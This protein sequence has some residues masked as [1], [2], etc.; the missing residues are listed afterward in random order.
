MNRRIAVTIV[1]ALLGA[2]ILVSLGVWQ[3]QRHQWKQGVLSRIDATIGAAPVELPANPDAARH[4]FLP[5]RM[6]GR[7]GDAEIRVQSSL[8]LVGA[9]YRVIAPFET[10]DGRR[11]LVD[12]GF[13]RQSDRDAA[14]PGGRAVITGNLH[15]PDE[16]DAFTPAPDPDA[17]LWFARDLTGLAERL[18]T[19]AVLVVVRDSSLAA[20]RIT[21][22]PLDSAGIPD[23]HLGYA[24]QWFLLAAVWATMSA[25]F[26]RGQRRANGKGRSA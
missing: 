25:I 22:L 5:V 17:G 19:E 12:R 26:V 8:K 7:V 18:D 14:R 20:P 16:L 9:G 21:R 10:D 6:S 2:V 3:L 15:W 4:A 24:I 13:V 1:F 23:N 11:V